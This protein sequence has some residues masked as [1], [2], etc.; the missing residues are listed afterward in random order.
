MNREQ[1]Y[2]RPLT[3]EDA[4]VSWRWRN[5]VGLWQ[6]TGDHPNVVVSEEMEREW[7]T[8]VIADS[9][10]INF[11]ICLK[12]SNRYIGNIYLVNVADGIGELGIFIGERD[13]HGKGYGQEAISLL[14]RMVSS[15]YGIKTIRIDVKKGNTAALISYLKAGGKIEGD[16]QWLRLVIKS[17]NK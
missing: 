16:S 3:V 9:T 15:D 8:K 7:A 14:K 4:A 6:F 11:A 17:E 1:V 2:L 12:P 5:D 10:R 13:C